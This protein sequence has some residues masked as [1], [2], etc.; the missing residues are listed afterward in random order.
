MLL[1]VDDDLNQLAL[2]RVILER[3]GYAVLTAGDARRGMQLFKSEAPD[4]VVLD[5]EMPLINGG[6][7][8]ERIRRVNRSIPIVMLSACNSVPKWVLK[9]VNT[10]IRKPTAPSCLI[11][12]I[13][14][15][16]RGREAV[17]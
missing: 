4:A 9:A 7:L 10:F 16:T 14:F 12:A 15:L 2:R 11:G 13:E 8:A 5:Y 3:S 17:A 6:V 1:L